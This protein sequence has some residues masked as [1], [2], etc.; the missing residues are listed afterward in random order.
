MSTRGYIIVKVK[1]ENKGKSLKFDKSLLNGVRLQDENKW[2]GKSF[3]EL[4]DNIWKPTKKVTGNYL[5]IYN[6]CDSYPTGA[7]QT[8]LAHFNSYEQ[9][10]NLVAGG[11][12]ES[13][14]G[15]HITYCK[16]R[17]KSLDEDAHYEDGSV[18]CQLHLPT[19]CESWQYLFYEGRWYVRQWGSRWYDLEEYLTAKG[20]KADY[21]LPDMKQYKEIPAWTQDEQAHELALAKFEM[22]WNTMLPEGRG[23]VHLRKAATL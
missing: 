18:P 6:Q 14:F 19:A 1:D 12:T 16:G 13:V 7:G 3:G 5:A 15:D 20:D 22:V 9:A 2:N 4:T 10:L 8:L 11:T 21:D 23:L 17:R